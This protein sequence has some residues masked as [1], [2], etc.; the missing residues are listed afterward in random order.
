MP[1]PN[2]AAIVIGMAVLGVIVN[3]SLHRIDEG[4]VGVYYRGGALLQAIA[5][6][7]FHMMVPLLTTFRSIQTTLQTDEVKITYF[8]VFAIVNVS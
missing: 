3:L 7:G 1:Q 8:Y 4:H 6:P 5:R 2:P